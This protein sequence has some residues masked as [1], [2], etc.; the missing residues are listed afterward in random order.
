MP[1][2]TVFGFVV[3]T[4]KLFLFSIF[5]ILFFQAC[6][7]EEVL[8]EK[9]EPSHSN[10]NFSNELNPNSELNIFNYLY[11]YNGGGVAAGDYNQDGLIDLYFTS[12]EQGDKLFLNSGNF[13]FKEITSVSQIDNSQGWTKGVSYIDIN[14]DSYTH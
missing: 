9:I 6:K 7:K 11:Y 10:L 2:N 1:Q 13:K 4:K 8:F 5:I 3:K 12:N 14:A